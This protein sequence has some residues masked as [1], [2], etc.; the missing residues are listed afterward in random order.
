MNVNNSSLTQIS[1]AQMQ[2]NLPVQAQ[3]AQSGFPPAM[4]EQSEVNGENDNDGDDGTKNTLAQSAQAL[5]QLLNKQQNSVFPTTPQTKDIQSILMKSIE[6]LYAS[7]TKAYANNALN[8]LTG[9][10]NIKV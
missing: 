5:S 7:S 6:A 10:M 2:N 9:G 1:Y 3:S 8:T 4:L